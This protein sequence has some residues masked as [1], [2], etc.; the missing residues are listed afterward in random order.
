MSDRK[1]NHLQDDILKHIAAQSS[2]R[3]KLP[4]LWLVPPQKD[5]GYTNRTFSAIVGALIGAAGKDS[6]RG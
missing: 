1:E 4:K 2:S 5:R 3:E 6:S